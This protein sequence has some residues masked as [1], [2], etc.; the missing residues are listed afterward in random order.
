MHIPNDLSCRGMA[1]LWKMPILAVLILV[2]LATAFPGR[3][4]KEPAAEDKLKTSL[5]ELEKQSWEAWQKRDGEFF[6]QFLSEDHVEVGFAGLANKATVVAGVTSPNCMVKSYKVEKFRL[7]MFDANTALLT[8]R[9]E[10]DTVCSGTT[11]PSPV[12]ASSLYVKRHNHW[13]NA[14][15]QQTQTRD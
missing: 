1:V 11:V 10:Q 8:Y 15:Y 7:A 4:Q 6:R 14:F 12:W 3:T 13:V 9:A 2:I 5:I